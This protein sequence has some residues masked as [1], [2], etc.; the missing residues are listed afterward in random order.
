LD[1]SKPWHR[2]IAAGRKWCELLC[3]NCNP[4]LCSKNQMRNQ[5]SC[6]RHGASAGTT[7]RTT[8]SPAH[9]N[10]FHSHQQ[11]SAGRYGPPLILVD[12]WRRQA[13]QQSVFLYPKVLPLAA[14]CFNFGCDK[15]YDKKLPDA[16]TWLRCVRDLSKSSMFHACSFLLCTGLRTIDSQ[17][18]CYRMGTMFVCVC[19]CACVC[20]CAMVRFAG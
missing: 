5:F 3:G 7:L 4:S 6:A 16:A 15:Y 13:D 12:R 14:M 1:F 18:V 2:S 8:S 10:C 19:V 11:R 9:G 17:F 20:L